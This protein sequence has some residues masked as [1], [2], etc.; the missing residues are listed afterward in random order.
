[1]QRLSIEPVQQIDNKTLEEIKRLRTN[2]KF[3]EPDQKVI[4]ITSTVGKEG[5]SMISFWL[6]HS[7]AELG[8]KV[9][10][11][12][13]NIRSKN[14]HNIFTTDKD[15]MQV[16]DMKRKKKDT[17]V[18]SVDSYINIDGLSDYLLGKTRKEEVACETSVSKLNIITAGRIPT[19]PT[20]LL[21]GFM[22]KDLITYL[23][24]NYDYVIIDTPA[25][26]EVTDSAIIAAHC[27]S[28][29]LVMEPGVAPYKL[30]QKVVEQLN[31]SGSK[32]LGVILNKA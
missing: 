5:K 11:V 31:T 7:L 26:G 13:A 29:I 19:N 18:E 14:K 30:A 12:D 20:E 3:R 22:L 21:S 9:V 32:L 8:S 6:A 15:N 10:L 17:K 16:S 25:L 4:N 24:E 2:L 23:R 27:D 1:M 28:S